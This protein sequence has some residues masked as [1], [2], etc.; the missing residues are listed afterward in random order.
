MQDDL[1]DAVDWAI[2]QGI[3]DPQKVAI[4]G[5]SYGGYAALA[6]LT[7][8]PDKFACAIDLVGISN[9]LTFM[10]TTPAYWKPFKEMEKRQVGGD[11]DTEEGRKY[12]ASK[13]PINFVD[14][15]KKP[16]LIGHGL[17]DPRVNVAE[18]EQIVKAMQGRNVPVVYCLFPDEG[19][20]FGKW[21]NSFAFYAVVENFL[22]KHLGGRY[23]AYWYDVFKESSIQIKAGIEHLENLEHYL[24]SRKRQN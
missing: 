3:A 1:I 8:T 15:I 7:F 24:P 4:Y 20:G 19:H 13:S 10:K 23:E 18:S 11:P 14:K 9:L 5:G 16:L 2:T 12:L 6:A 17:N 22:A 21:Q